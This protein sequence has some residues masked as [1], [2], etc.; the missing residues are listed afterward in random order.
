MWDG[1]SEFNQFF[2]ELVEEL[3]NFSQDRFR[4]LLKLL[5]FYAVREIIVLEKTVNVEVVLMVSWQN[6]SLS[7]NTFKELKDCSL[8]F[9]NG[10][11]HIGVFLFEK[12]CI[13]FEHEF[14]DVFAAKLPEMFLIDNFLIVFGELHRIEREFGVAEVHEKYNRGIFFFLRKIFHL[15]ETIVEAD[16]CWLGYE[17]IAIFFI[18]TIP[19]NF[20]GIEKSLPLGLGQVVGNSHNLEFVVKFVEF[21][22]G[23]Y[24]VEQSCGCLLR[25]QLLCFSLAF[26]F[27]DE[28]VFWRF[29]LTRGMFRLLLDVLWC[30]SKP[31]VSLR[32]DDS[33]GEVGFHFDVAGLA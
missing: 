20:D 18:H 5:S 13:E 26:G 9:M 7:L 27:E 30:L 12:T 21:D 2:F 1:D 11:V 29:G 33:V 32:C 31:E 25:G 19:W 15:V 3:C 16:S 14:V 6:F 10:N 23:V 17:L 8:A 28:S 24:F 4:D 22:D